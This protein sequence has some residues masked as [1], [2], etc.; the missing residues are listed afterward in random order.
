MKEANYN[1]TGT[2]CQ[3][4]MSGLKR[5]YKNITDSNKKL[6]NHFS[7]WAFYSAMGS[8]FGEKAWVDP[9]SIANSDN[10]SS[11][12]S[13]NLSQKSLSTMEANELKPK[14]RRVEPILESFVIEIKED[15]QKERE[16]RE[17]RRAEKIERQ[18]QMH[19]E[20]MQ[21]QQSLLKVL[22]K[23]TEHK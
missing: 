18:N 4:K 21:L 14:K 19:K 11:P 5:T 15:K 22:T 17:W 8:I 20:K 10:P 1:V 7:S 12:G 6:G 23:F 3:N 2:Q 16:D 9:V 13:S